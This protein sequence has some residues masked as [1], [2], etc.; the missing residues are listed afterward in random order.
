MKLRTL[1]TAFLSTLVAVLVLP[2][3]AR[4]TDPSQA[5]VVYDSSEA[6]VTVFKKASCKVVKRHEGGGKRFIAKAKSPE[7]WELEVYQNH[8]KGFGQEY[9]IEY[10]IRDTNFILRPTEAKSPYYSNFFFPGD[11]APPFNGALAL[12]GNGKDMGIGTIAAFSSNGNPDDAVRFVGHAKC[13]YPKKR[14]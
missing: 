9:T 10:G 2:A 11:E 7:G 14:R 12:S 4:A 8:F 6:E 13:K 5:I 1:A 3:L